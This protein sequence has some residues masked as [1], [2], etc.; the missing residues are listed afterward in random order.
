MNQSTNQNQRPGLLTILCILS[1]IGSGLAS[2][3]NFFVYFNYEVILEMIE[4]ES[5]QAMGY[6][7]GV[8]GKISRSYFLISALLQVLSF[9]GVRLMWSLRRAGFH[10]YAISQLLL[11]IVS[12]IYIYKP[13]D[14][15]PMFDLLLAT[16]FIL[17]YL[18]FRN[19]MQ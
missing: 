12:T 16:I 9:N 6:D 18:R 15:F 2:V 14:M 3:S 1:F 13:L 5:F 7:F 10:L 4:E 8:F 17:L 11:L 19:Q